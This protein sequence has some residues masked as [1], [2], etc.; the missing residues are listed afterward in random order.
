MISITPDQI[1]PP[2]MAL[3][4]PTHPTMPRAFN[5]LEGV[6]RG[7]ILVDHADRPSW[8]AARENAFGTLYL[9]GQCNAPLLDSLLTY[10]RSIGDV[11]LGCWL[12]SE[13]ND[14][15]P[16]APDYDGRTLY[17]TEHA[18][19]HRELLNAR[20]PTGYSITPRNADLV[21]QS[22]DYQMN[23]DSLGSIDS[24]LHHTLGFVVLYE[25]QLVCEASTGA[26][27][28][29]RIEIGVNTAEAHRRRGLAAMACAHLIEACKEKGYS[30]WWDCAKQNTASA[31]L[32]RKLGF[33]NER[34]YR[35]VWWAQMAT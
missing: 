14:I 18:P 24:I 8:A 29:G 13:L 32:A 34:E 7:Q 26:P 16:P 19:R 9:G 1:T 25:D 30:T 11:G 12:D 6:T 20:L 28:H 17:F 22:A 2:M 23:L 21:K 27:T 3:F 5:V 33:E 10:F 35:Y 4:D 15:L 31:N